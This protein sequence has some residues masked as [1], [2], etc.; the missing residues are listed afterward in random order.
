MKLRITIILISFLTLSFIPTDASAQRGRSKKKSKSSVD[1]A[2]DKDGDLLDKLWFGGMVSPGF[3]GNNSLNEFTFG[4]SPMVGYKITNKLSIG[5]RISATYRHLRGNGS[6]DGFNIT[7]PERGNTLSTS[8]ALFGRYK[9]LPAIFAHVEYERSVVNYNQV[10]VVPSIIGTQYFLRVDSVTNE[11]IK[12]RESRENAYVGLGYT[13]TG[14][15]LNTEISVLY[16]VL[17]N[18]QSLSIP[19]VFRFGLNYNF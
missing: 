13:S 15:I 9:I 12:S 2:F 18:S 5:P 10:W 7:G 14:G 16:N 11:T 17:E 1:K 4:I 8:Y 6:I 19:I 3:S